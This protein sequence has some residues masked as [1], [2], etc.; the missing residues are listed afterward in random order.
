MIDMPIADIPRVYTALA[1]W[2]A[3]LSYIIILEK[4]YKTVRTVL[5]LILYFL[6]FVSLQVFAGTLP[7]VFWIPCMSAAVGVILLCIWHLCKVSGKDAIYICVRAFILAEFIASFEWMCR[8][9][10]AGKA[11]LP[12]LWMEWSL[13]AF[14]YAAIFIVYHLLE[15][16]NM[17]RKWEIHCS[18]REMAGAILVAVGTFLL[19]NL[20]FV[21]ENSMTNSFAI[22]YIRTL[23]D[24]VGLVMLF[25]QQV[26]WQE[27]QARTEMDALKT[28]LQRHYQQYQM[29]SENIELLKREFHDLKHLIMAIK[30]EKDPEK[31]VGFLTQM[32]E[33]IALQ[34]AFIKTENNVL[35]TVL[36]TKGIF[37]AQN[38]IKFT[39]LGDGKLLEFMHAIDI[40]SIFGNALDNAIE[41]TLK[42]PD[43]DKR[44]INVAIYERSGF[45]LLEFENYFEENLVMKSD[46][47]VT[48]KRD[49]FLH[50]YGLKSIRIAAEKYRGTMTIN[51]D[52]NWFT[53][54]ILFPNVNEEQ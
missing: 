24:F 51:T 44:L 2:V 15:K 21:T 54:R 49:K 23:F 42:M 30:T 16:R 10:L 35:D 9:Y 46:I 1:E 50:G 18:K 29:S 20:S 3:C 36:T 5:W 39:C 41:S 34:E 8:V 11:W 43:T 47:P 52:N 33:S 45:I 26:H 32:E 17:P 19:S 37:C 22:V 4:R 7:V 40:C 14:I 28:I 48:T 6:V 25:N 31:K 53:L 13:V 12:Y 27:L 38:A